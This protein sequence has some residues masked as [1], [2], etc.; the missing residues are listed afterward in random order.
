M[1]LRTET[2]TLSRRSGN[3]SLL[4]YKESSSC[5]ISSLFNG[6]HYEQRA[7]IKESCSSEISRFT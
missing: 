7:V 3:R 5:S 4:K 1:N 6:M 2:L